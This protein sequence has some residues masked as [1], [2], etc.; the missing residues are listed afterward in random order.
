MIKKLLSLVI[1]FTFLFN[2]FQYSAFSEDT[3]IIIAPNQVLSDTGS[4]DIIEIQEDNTIPDLII[5][6]QQP[7]YLI[8]KDQVLETYHCDSNQGECRVNFDLRDTFGGYI[9]T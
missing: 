9:P 8:D 5:S 2:N 7:S 6:F 3:E 4:I 1:V